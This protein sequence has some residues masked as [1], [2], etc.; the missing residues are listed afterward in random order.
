MNRLDANTSGDQF[1][2]PDTATLIRDA[3][4]LQGK[5]IIDG[6]RDAIL[7]PV[8]FGAA[9]LSIWQRGA[10][11]GRLFY[12]VVRMGRRS[13]RWI[14]LFAAADR[15]CPG[16]EDSGDIRGLDDYLAQVEARLV[17]QYRS[18]DAGS[19]ARQAVDGLVDRIHAARQRFGEKQNKPGE[20]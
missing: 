17:D 13:E 9:L 7:I 12:E 20:L 14:N 15:V 2:P 1:S 16:A 8:S 6:L 5:L 10:D 3:L 18:G 11:K 19:P 4:V